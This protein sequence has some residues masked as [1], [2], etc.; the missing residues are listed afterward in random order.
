MSRLVRPA[1]D[2]LNFLENDMAKIIVV[3]F[4]LCFSG[5]SMHDSVYHIAESRGMDACDIKF[6]YRTLY[7]K[8][9]WWYLTTHFRHPEQARIDTKQKSQI[10]C[11]EKERLELMRPRP[12]QALIPCDNQINACALLLRLYGRLPTQDPDRYEDEDD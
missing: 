9:W 12:A 1:L 4:L 5:W 7:G 11:Q 8:K 2:W 3:S 6:A 10:L